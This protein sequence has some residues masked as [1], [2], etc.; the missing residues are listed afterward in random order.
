MNQTGT[1]KFKSTCS[2]CG[3]GCGVIVEKNSKGQ[4]KVTGDESHPVNK[5]M[6][7]SKGMNLHYTVSD[8]SD[9]ILYPQMRWARNQPRQRVSWDTALNRASAV[10]GTFIN[11][12]GPDSVGFYVSGQCLTEEYYTVNK[13]A[14]GFVGTN[15]VDT[16]SRLCMSSAVVGYKKSLGE[17]SVPISYEDIE[18][19]NCF[20]ITGA[21]PAWCHPILFRRIEAHKEKHPD[22]K[23]IVADPRE[24][25]SC[26]IADLHLQLNPGTDT[27]LYH[28]IARCLIETDRIDESFVK[29]HTDGFEAF[30]AQVMEQSLEYAASTCGLEIREIKQAAQWIGDANGFISMWAMGLNQSVD[31]T[32]KN[33]ALINLSLITGQVGKP[34]SGPFSLTGQPNA[35]GGR[36]VGGMANLLTAHR[37]LSNPQ[38][39]QEVA[40]IWG[41]DSVPAK[42]GYT[43]TEMVDALHSGDL[44]AIWIICTNPVVSLPNSAMVDAA[45]EKAKFVIVQDISKDSETVDYADLVLPAAGY[46]EKEGTMTNSERR[47]SYLNKVVDPPGEALP[48]AE[49]LCRFGQKMGYHGFDFESPSEIF[50]EHCRMTKGTNIDISGLSY[51]YLKNNGTVQWPFPEGATED[52]KRLF[53]DKK[54]YTEN[55][56]A[57]I[58][59]QNVKEPD[60]EGEDKPLMLTTGRIRDQWH[61]RTRTGKVNR[62]NQHIGE[63][64]VEINPKDARDRNIADGDVVEV[65]N[66]RGRVRLQATISEEIKPGV[67]FIPMHWGKI[68]KN[69]FPR[70]N[71]LT[72][73][74]IDPVSKEPDFKYSTVEVSKFEKAKEKI[75]VVGAGAAAY[76]FVNRYR[77]L[78]S[79]DEI[80]VFSKEEYPFYNRVLLPDYISG[81]LSWE[82]LQKMK[83]EQLPD[84]DLT[85]HQGVSVESVDPEKKTV[86]DSNRETHS[87]DQLIL[88]TGSSANFP[89]DIPNL[90]GVFTIRHRT[91]AD[92]LREYTDNEGHVLIVGGG[93]LGLEM[94][95]SLRQVDMEVT[96]VDRN[97]RLM[98]R[99]LDQTASDL[100]LEHIRDCN[101]NVIFNDEVERLTEEDD[102]IR[103]GL[104]SGKIIDSKAVVFAIGTRPNT[105]LAFEAGLQ[106]K[107]GVVVNE[108]L[109]T[110]DPSIY[111]IGEIAE[112]K[113]TMNGITAAAEEQAEI[114]AGYISGDLSSNYAGSLSMNIL[115][116][117]NLDLCS[118]GMT[119][120]PEDDSGYEEIVLLDRSQRFYKKCIVHKDKLVGA[121]LM[122]D[123][124]EFNDFRMLI[125]SEMELSDRRMELLRSGQA[126]P[127][128]KGEL[129]CSCNNVGDGNVREAIE[130]G[131]TQLDQ[132]CQETGAGTGCGS[133]KPEVKAIL[134]Q[135]ESEQVTV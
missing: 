89:R 28:A 87:Y 58:H 53:T 4:I 102:H 39:R 104:K 66:G 113:G 59:T 22:V 74:R 90:P 18:L 25:Q 85:L 61:T 120:M 96:I 115:K 81:E 24:T 132:L 86:L 123:K 121:I 33:L 131:C 64:Y 40:D 19:A 47:I 31:G 9:R 71:N 54:F 95:A 127:P 110:S 76:R 46:L 128:M 1:E 23:I 126:M 112:F 77:E 7:C 97:P 106:C 122:G 99:Q 5:G 16:N 133:C 83:A 134:E 3:V 108:H 55:G 8:H 78:N 101:I 67:V 29:N 52:K 45:L 69:D 15:N 100:L 34:G 72:S 105:R 48:D 44:K 30:K 92:E 38:H 43:A 13:L 37:N 21:N 107:R 6:L 94:A 63:P 35:M 117:P 56:R 27:V 111:A 51:E 73:D 93:L 41:V 2:Y 103:A 26:S 98:E 36:E 10:F 65:L 70:A 88:A 125:E 109:Q 118:L 124:A 57:Q 82:R 20:F 116:F 79:E 80:E 129:I 50:A 17:D 12:Y 75:L 135:F 62:L 60:R 49:I 14:K 11:K 91:D 42:P 68:L 114:A 130:G 84:L 32:D 119:E